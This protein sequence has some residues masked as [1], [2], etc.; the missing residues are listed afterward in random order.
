VDVRGMLARLLAINHTDE[1]TRR[2]GRNAVILSLGLIALV[3]LVAIV[4]LFQP[5]WEFTL[6][7]AVISVTALSAILALARRGNVTAAALAM[8]GFVTLLLFVSS[9][10]SGRVGIVPFFLIVSIL[11]ASITVRPGT[12]ALTLALNIVA[13]LLLAWLLGNT[14]Q[15]PPALLEVFGYGGALCG[16][17]GLIGILG[18]GSTERALRTAQQARDQ[19][20]RAAAALDQANAALALRTNALSEALAAQEAQSLELREALETQQRLDEQIAALA[21]P[22]IPIRADVLVIPL[23]GTLDRARADQLRHRALEQIQRQH[24]RIVILDITGVPV[25]DREVAQ[26]LLQTANAARLLGT[27]PILVGI[28]PEVAQALVS[29]NVNLADLEV[30]ATLQQSLERLSHTST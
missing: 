7:A 15:R 22:V 25:V 23:I 8:I 12:V 28:R 4:G 18:A 3:V 27:R 29:L 19:A 2:R 10:A 16:F 17:A 1:D 30:H 13:L 5:G 26:E 24:A 11:L 21:L 9:W 14:E 6:A 20:E